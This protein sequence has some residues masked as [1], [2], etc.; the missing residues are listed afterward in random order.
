M[1]TDFIQRINQSIDESFDGYKCRINGLSEPVLIGD[2]ENFVPAVIDF[3]GECNEVFVDDDYR[4]GCYHRLISKQYQTLTNK[5]YGD[6]PKEVQIFDM[7]LV[8]WGF[9]GS[10]E[11]CEQ[12]IYSHLPA[13]VKVL[14]SDF[15]KQKI[16]KQEIKGFN[17][18]LP[19]E[20]F[21]FLI[22]YRVQQRT[23]RACVEITDVFI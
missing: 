4:F 15:D 23:S 14:S 6:T 11:A 2:D 8:C 5:G 3:N 20:V 18:D 19:P 9:N 7:Y 21:L 13:D 16:F 1:T 10:S 12:L 22:K 17:G